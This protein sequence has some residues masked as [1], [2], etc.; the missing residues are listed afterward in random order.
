MQNENNSYR[1]RTE[2]GNNAPNVLNVKLNQTFEFLNILS[3][4]IGQEN[5]YKVPAAPYGVVLGRVLANQVYGIENAKVSIFIPKDETVFEVKDDILYA[6]SSTTSLNHD[7]VRYNLLPSYVDEACHQNVGTMFEK[8]YVLDNNDVIRIF[9][10]YYTY[11]TR[12]NSS[13]DYF[14]YGVPV[15]QHTLH[16]DVDLSDIGKLSVRPHDMIGQGYNIGMF[17]SPNKFKA[18]KNLNMLP[19]IKSQ[20]K[21]IQVYPFWGDTSDDDT[22]AMI[23]RADIEIDYKFEPTAVFMGSIISDK[24]SNSISHKCVPD[25]RTG[26]MSELSTG[27]G[28]IEMIRKTF[29]GRVEEFSVNGNQLIDNNGVWCYQIPMNLDYVGMDEFG[30]IVPTDNPEKGLPT[31]ARVRFRVSMDEDPMDDSARKR[32]K[33]LIPNNP[34]LTDDYPEFK[35][36]HEADY[37]FGTFTKEESYRDLFWNNV[38]TVKSYIPRLQRRGTANTKKFTGI[39]M[40]NH[41]GDNNPMP[42]NNLSIKM[43]FMYIFLCSV[44]TVL[45]NFIYAL[46]TV[47]SFVGRVLINAGIAL[48]SFSSGRQGIDCD[49]NDNDE[50]NAEE[51]PKK[52]LLK[53]GVDLVVAGIKCVIRI[54]PDICSENATPDQYIILG[55]KKSLD[56]WLEKIGKICKK[57]KNVYKRIRTSCAFKK[58]EIGDEGEEINGCEYYS[59]LGGEQ[60]IN[61]TKPGFVM[62][63]VQ[64]TLAQE[65]EVT[66]F[67]FHNDWINGVLYAPL[68][69]RKIKPR[70]RVRNTN[71]SI[72]KVDDW[73]NGESRIDTAYTG[74]K[75]KKVKLCQ[76]CAQQRNFNPTNTNRQSIRPIDNFKADGENPKIGYIHEK[77]CYGFKCHRKVTSLIRVDDGIIIRRETK[78]GEYVYYYK[79][80]EYSEDKF[81]NILNPSKNGEVKLLFATDLVLLGSLNDCDTNGT[82]QF[83]KHLSETTYQ[84]PPDLASLSWDTIDKEPTA[85]GVENNNDEYEE[86]D[87]SSVETEFTGA[88]YG[89][90]GKD[91]WHPNEESDEYNNYTYKGSNEYDNGGLFYDLTC[92]N[93]FVSPKGCVN[94]SRVCEFGVS[95]DQSMDLATQNGVEHIA[96]DGFISYDELYNMDARSMF[97]TMNCNNLRERVNPKTGYKVYDFNYNYP[98][99]FDGAMKSLMSGIPHISNGEVIEYSGNKN[100]ERSSNSYLRFRYGFDK[101]NFVVGFYDDEGSVVRNGY[102]TA[103]EG[104]YTLKNVRRFPRY[105]NSFYFYFGLKSGST[106]INRFMEQF[107]ADCRNDEEGS[108][109]IKIDYKPNGWC[110]DSIE[111]TRDGYISFD[112][113]NVELPCA[114]TFNEL[115]EGDTFDRTYTD[116]YSYKLYIG[117]YNEDLENDGYERLYVDAATQTKQKPE[118]EAL[119]EDYVAPLLPNGRYVITIT[120]VSGEEYRENV[121]FSRNKLQ[122]D[123]MVTHFALSNSELEN[124]FPNT[125]EHS[126]YY[127]T[128]SDTTPSDNV[129]LVRE[130]GGYVTIS[131]IDGEYGAITDNFIIRV[132]SIIDLPDYHGS[133]YKVINGNVS[134]DGIKFISDNNGEYIFGLPKANTQY[135]ITVTEYCPLTETESRNSVSVKITPEEPIPFKM[136][137]NG[138]DNT[139][140]SKFRTGYIKDSNGVITSPYSGYNENVGISKTEVIG[141]LDIGNVGVSKLL[142]YPPIEAPGSYSGAVSNAVEALKQHDSDVY[143]FTDEYYFD[144]SELVMEIDV[145]DEVPSPQDTGYAKY[146][147]VKTNDDSFD[148]TAY[149]WKYNQYSNAYQPKL[150]D[151]G[152]YTNV[153]TLEEYYESSYDSRVYVIDAINDV[154]Q[155]RL[156]LVSSMYDAFCMYEDAEGGKTIS[157]TY[158]TNAIPV[159]TLVYYVPDTTLT[160]N[161]S[162]KINGNGGN[163]Q[164]FFISGSYNMLDKNKEEN[165]ITSFGLPTISKN[166]DNT[167]PIFTKMVDN[168]YKKPPY[169][170]I[171]NQMGMTVPPETGTIPFG[172][173]SI[174]SA[175]S[176]TEGGMDSMFGFHII[177]KRPFTKLN[178][179]LPIKNYPIYWPDIDDSNPTTVNGLVRGSY[180]DMNGCVSGYLYN[181]ISTSSNRI[182]EFA[183]QDIGKN[184]NFYT[185]TTKTDDITGTQIPDEYAVPTKR[186]MYGDIYPADYVYSYNDFIKED[187]PFEGFDSDSLDTGGVNTTNRYIS[188]DSETPFLTIEDSKILYQ[189]NLYSSSEFGLPEDTIVYNGAAVTPVFSN[190]DIR[191]LNYVVY[192]GK[193]PIYQK[194]YD[195]SPRIIKNGVNMT[196]RNTLL[197]NSYPIIPSDESITR[198]F[199]VGYANNGEYRAISPTY[200]VSKVYVE[201]YS[202]PAVNGLTVNLVYKTNEEFRDYY[203]RYYPHEIIVEFREVIGQDTTFTMPE[204]D[205]EANDY[206]TIEPQL[207]YSGM[208]T[209]KSGILEGKYE[210][211]YQDP[212]GNRREAY[213]FEDIGEGSYIDMESVVVKVKDVTGIIRMTKPFEA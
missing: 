189:K 38:Y 153:L 101:D 12:T 139:L 28:K 175:M 59:R 120:D 123:T 42:Y 107:Y 53:A 147:R 52:P 183:Q 20:D 129:E 7:G 99:N 75:V 122:F 47:L 40:V 159:K 202:N 65:N 171:K 54:N 81:K 88:D 137:V 92:S 181:C 210:E 77:T 43:N 33:F 2:V 60:G 207:I 73:C 151:N 114:I 130:I 49:E 168:M 69:Y 22:N 57:N 3:L 116:I 25:I 5:L 177:D 89:N 173:N 185:I 72:N 48:A 146:V 44:M 124:R 198:V 96:P 102:T 150:D 32:A 103:G 121:M 138:V 176:E 142:E 83:F 10:K 140:L 64:N 186:L 56:K 109:I 68:W 14:I 113:T 85:Y 201:V 97:S 188:F 194:V 128:A 26:K 21:P 133:E 211:L 178:V 145:Y 76:T 11:T 79:S 95:L 4:K 36:S 148:E 166:F 51:T 119:S 31:R 98:E 199:F 160:N 71:I 191:G 108:N 152:N 39:K 134:Y 169:C 213:I 104:G 135:T 86:I 63:C 18:D 29:D 9:N 55:N 206:V 174:V 91:Q 200:E 158:Q 163:S 87:S 182:A 8:E 180:F 61:A 162:G 164:I 143:S 105:E 45:V 67:N 196:Y 161:I 115:M 195:N 167:K 1:I 190:M 24:G 132:N 19:Q 111:S 205:Y 23:T 127:Y 149:I 106:A 204:W 17:E 118:D 172:T 78:Y 58:I 125:D 27:Q 80:L 37:N 155:K 16:V 13:G 112:L 100:L 94:M 187:N 165:T 66:S 209:V 15:G 170:A 93:S 154:I 62:N 136:F 156:D 82:P 41:S 117:A 90:V 157:I 208:K 192:S 131:G 74:K 203:L 46:N 110:E 193:N 144:E 184:V 197:F 30:N 141:W 212:V 179:W 126:T 70:R 34:R 6:Y 35:N 84:M 50:D